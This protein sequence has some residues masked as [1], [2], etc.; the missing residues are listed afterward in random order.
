MNAKQAAGYRAAEWVEDGM[1][2]GLG[3]GSTAY[4]AIEKIGQRV[5]QGLKI[6]A[7]ATSN[8]SEELAKKYNIP[9]IRAAEVEH[10]DLAIDGADE[11]DANMALTKGGGGALLREKLV[12]INSERFIVIAD[13]S[14]MVPHLGNF[15]LPIEIVPFCYE[16][17]FGQLQRIYNVPIEMRTRDGELYITDNGNYIADA[18][19]GVISDPGKLSHELKAMTGVVEHGLFVDIAHT[20]VVG[21]EDGRTEVI[22]KK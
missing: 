11:V 8:A 17:A 18:S 5:A 1:I 4:Y 14:K 3:T 2:V 13:H 21:Y 9:L 16:W 20:V 10:L 22:E 19:F 6:K 15:K 7:I 12:A